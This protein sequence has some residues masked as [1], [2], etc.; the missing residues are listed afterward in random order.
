M[1][2]IAGVATTDYPHHPELT[3]L[4][5]H[6]IAADRALA[7]AGIGWDEIDGYASAGFFPMHTVQLCEYMTNDRWRTSE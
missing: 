1:A 6:A 2:V 4:G 3:E 7:D 5:V